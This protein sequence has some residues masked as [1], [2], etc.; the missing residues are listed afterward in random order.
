MPV[1]ERLDPGAERSGAGEPVGD[2]ADPGDQLGDP[3]GEVDAVAADVVERQRHV[4]PGP[5]VL[6]HGDAGQD[7]VEA[8]LPGVV[9]DPREAVRLPVLLVEAPPDAGLPHPGGHRVEVV[10]AEAEPAA[11]RPAP[12][13]GRAAGSR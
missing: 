13:P 3:S 11:D 4:E 2:L 9:D 12:G 1:G 8:E 10:V 5:R 6:A 7:P